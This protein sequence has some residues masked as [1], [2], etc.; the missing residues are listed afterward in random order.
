MHQLINF[1]KQYV[2]PH[3]GFAVKTW[4]PWS[5][6]DKE[7]QDGVQKR[8][9][10]M[11]SALRGTSYEKKRAELDMDNPGGEETYVRCKITK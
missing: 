1:Y 9:V 2:K 4:S 8:A 10:N 6:Q 7:P 5:E 11:V 3:L